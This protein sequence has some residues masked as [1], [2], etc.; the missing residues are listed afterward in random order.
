MTIKRKLEFVNFNKLDKETLKLIW[1]WRTSSDIRT[2]MSD[3]R[4]FSLKEHMNFCSN[5]KDRKD[6]LFIL[7]KCDD[8]PV[9]VLTY[10]NIDPIKHSCTTGCYF[11]NAPKNVS[12]MALKIMTWQLYEQEIYIY[13]TVVLKNNIQALLYNVL[14]G[15][16]KIIKE[17]ER[18]YYLEK[19]F[20]QFNDEEN[21]EERETVCRLLLNN[22][23]V[24]NV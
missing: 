20:S 10:K 11:V 9:G 3:Q 13:H 5:L 16:N 2:K 7:V 18:Y 22:E 4:V 19:D 15:K 24:F 8:T 17:D 12:F 23:V 21:K 6:V 14:K 1:K